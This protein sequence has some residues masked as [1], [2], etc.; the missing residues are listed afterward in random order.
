M[1]D[2]NAVADAKQ[3]F[4]NYLKAGD[5]QPFFILGDALKTLATFPAGCLDCCMTSPPYWGQRAYAGGGIGLEGTYEEYVENL[6]AITAEVKSN[7]RASLNEALAV[8]FDA[9]KVHLF[10]QATGLALPRR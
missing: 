8:A 9:S 2:A 5:L 4:I 6:L 10:D 1:A 7:V 3:A